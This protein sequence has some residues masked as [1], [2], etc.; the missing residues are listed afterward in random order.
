MV[1]VAA[2]ESADREPTEESAIATAAH[3]TA[4]VAAEAM[5]PMVARTN[6]L[7]T[8]LFYHRMV[9]HSSTV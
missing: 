2:L 3:N 7:I 9:G 8:V 4:P 1:V 5:M 6:S